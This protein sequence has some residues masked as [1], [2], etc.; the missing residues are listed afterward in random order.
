MFLF[1]VIQQ[2][3]PEYFLYGCVVID[4]QYVYIILNTNEMELNS[5]AK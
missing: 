4:V 3:Y 5:H 2:Q 1:L